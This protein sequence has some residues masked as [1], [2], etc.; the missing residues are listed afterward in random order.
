MKHPNVTME[1]LK[2]NMM[3]GYQAKYTFNTE[4]EAKA[5][6]EKLKAE[7]DKLPDFLRPKV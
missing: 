6:F 1:V 7:L 4:Q 2:A 3:R 5:Y